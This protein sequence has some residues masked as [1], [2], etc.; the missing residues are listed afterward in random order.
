MK[1]LYIIICWS[2][3]WMFASCNSD[4]FIEDF[5]PGETHTVNVSI[6]D[7]GKEVLFEGEEWGVEQIMGDMT[8]SVQAYTLDEEPAF[9][10]F[11]EGEL[12]IIRYE[13]EF[14]NFSIEKRSAD[15]LKIILKENLWNKPFEISIEVGGKYGRKFLHALLAPTQKYQIDS[16]VYDWSQFA[17]Y[18]GEL[19]PVDVIGVDNLYGSSPVALTVYPYKDSAREVSFN[20]NQG[21]GWDQECYERLLGEE[22]PEIVIPDMVDWKPVM[23]NTKVKFGMQYQKLDVGLDKGLAV[24]V[25]VDEHDRKNVRVYNLIEQYTLPYTVY[26]SN[27]ESGKKRV[28][29]GEMHSELPVDYFVYKEEIND[30]DYK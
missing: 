11:V 18:Q 23:G 15:Q 30:D 25:T 26:I 29:S 8:S 24:K 1:Y 9:L 16:I 17:T 21:L 4:V 6:E 10:P 14:L 3:A 27:P 2:C 12:G 7:N 5:L 28:I 13:D 20:D 22:L 19:K